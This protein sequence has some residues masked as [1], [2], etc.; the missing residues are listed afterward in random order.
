[1][2]TQKMFTGLERRPTAQKLARRAAIERRAERTGKSFRRHPGRHALE[3]VFLKPLLKAALQSTGLYARGVR[4]A[5]S[6]VIRNLSLQFPDLPAAFDGFR[7][8]HLSDLHIDCVEHLADAVADSL[9]GLDADVCLMTGDYRF[10]IEGACDASWA[11]MRRVLSNVTAPDGVYAILGNHDPCEMAEGLE[12]MNVEMLI[13][14]SVELRRGRSSIWI[15]GTDDSYDYRFDDL[16]AAMSQIPP[17]GFKVLLAHTPDAYRSAYEADVH[18]YL[19]GHTHAGQIRLP[20]IGSVIQNSEAP[21]AYT[22][23]YWNHH[24]MHGYTSAGIG[25]SMLPVR[26]NCPPEIVVIELRR[27]QTR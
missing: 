13:N 3:R 16:P 26:F 6:P 23:G 21:R 9:A 27:T 14:D 12:S 17:S 19:C 22:H 4:N 15:A 1:M 7:I 25:A 10:A 5:T 20:F 18:L 2:A 8:L 11:G 24:G